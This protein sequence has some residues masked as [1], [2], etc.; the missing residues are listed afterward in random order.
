M[1]ET[2]LTG[3]LGDDYGMHSAAQQAL[4]EKQNPYRME[5]TVIRP[6]KMNFLLLPTKK[7]QRRSSRKYVPESR[8][9]CVAEPLIGPSPE[10][11]APQPTIE[12]EEVSVAL[13][14]KLERARLG[15]AP[16][17]RSHHC[18]DHTIAYNITTM[19]KTHT[20]AKITPTQRSHQC[21]D[22]TNAKIILHPACTIAH[23]LCMQA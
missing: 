4:A 13:Q 6:H 3:P 17:Q 12:A 5:K 21:K 19:E 10:S 2:S 15:R 9:A 14:P 23:R 11:S 18:K 20:N 1:H 22:H 16:L 8:P 7:S